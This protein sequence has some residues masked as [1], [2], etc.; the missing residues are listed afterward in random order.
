MAKRAVPGAPQNDRQRGDDKEMRP[1]SF[2]RITILVCRI[3]IVVSVQIVSDSYRRLLILLCIAVCIA[4]A[5][6]GGISIGPDSVFAAAVCTAA[7]CSHGCGYN[8]A[9]AC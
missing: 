6:S 4:I 2:Q 1:I 9:R 5:I 3:S 8:S 7:D